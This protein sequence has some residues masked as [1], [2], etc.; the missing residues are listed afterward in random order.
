MTVRVFISSTNE[1]LKDD[2]RPSLIRAMEGEAQTIEMSSW[3]TDYENA[4]KVCREKIENESTHYVGL[5]AYRR[6]WVPDDPELEGKSIT[7]AEFYWAKQ[8]KKTMAVFVPNPVSEIA[9]TL[10]ARAEVPS[11]QSAADAAAQEAFLRDVSTHGA[12]MPFDDLVHLA[13]KVSRRVTVWAGGGLRGIA[14]AGAITPAAAGNPFRSEGE[15]ILLGRKKQV[16]AFEDLLQLLSDDNEAV[17]V[18][19]H[20]PAGYGHQEVL[21][22]LRAKL[23]ENRWEKRYYKG[24]IRPDW[25]RKD[26]ATLIEVVGR[27]MNPAATINSV[28]TLATQLRGA[29]EVSDVV[30]EFAE[31]QRLE[32]SL[33][34][35]AECFWK[36]LLGE[37]GKHTPHRLIALAT[38]EQP[39]GNRFTELVVD[40]DSIDSYAPTLI[41]ALPVLEKF[42]EAELKDWLRARGMQQQQAR[43][44]AQTLIA[45]TH[46]H[47]LL[48]YRKLEDDLSDIQVN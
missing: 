20:G 24:D 8:S 14:A 45:D 2:C 30:L 38:F 12:Y 42:K 5:F 43:D 46:G 22:R 31:L 44:I 10:R 7:E 16:R 18:L 26:T 21:K 13:I 11:Q 9:R 3:I 1:D 41:T 32:G 33:S 27:E 48:L 36:P 35:F 47:P 17:C 40:A 25:R 34:E 19:V 29:L 28:K 23:S 6:G 39:L 37:L 15:L 4:V